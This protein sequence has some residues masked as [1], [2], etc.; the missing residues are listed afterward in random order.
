MREGP[1]ETAAAA[2]KKS[3]EEKQAFLCGLKGFLG[4]C[5]SFD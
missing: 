4:H 2:K 1:D 5:S 3:K